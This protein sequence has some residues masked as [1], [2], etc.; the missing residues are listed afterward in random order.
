MADRSSQ[1]GGRPTGIRPIGHSPDLP[2]GQ[3]GPALDT[4]KTQ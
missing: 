2:Y 1:T 3:S 4:S